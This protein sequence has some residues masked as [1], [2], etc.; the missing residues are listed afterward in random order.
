M[1][2][3]SII[4]GNKIDVDRRPSNI[5]SVLDIVNEEEAE[6]KRNDDSDMKSLDMSALSSN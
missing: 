5:A 6:N 2:S 3:N 4:K 1:V